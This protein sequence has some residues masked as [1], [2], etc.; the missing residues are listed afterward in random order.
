MQRLLPLVL[1]VCALTPGA[2]AQQVERIEIVEWGIYR[3]DNLGVIPN[4]NAPSGTSYLAANIRHQQTTTTVPALVGITFGFRYEVAG[5]PPGAA[6]KLRTV[7]RF[8]RQGLTSPSSGKTFLSEESDR[9]TPVGGIGFK[10]YTLDYDWE[11]QT[12]PWTVEIWHG[13]RKL[14]EKTFM[15]TR[16]VSSAERAAP[17]DGAS[18]ATPGNRSC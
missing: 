9:S 7:V 1:L 13:D 4:P 11:V 12:G 17:R 5:S 2:R 18:L 8:P 15:V 10:G 6:V 3:T 14:A 16:L